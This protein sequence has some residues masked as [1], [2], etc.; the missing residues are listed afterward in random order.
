MKTWYICLS[1]DGSWGRGETVDAAKVAC[2]KASGSRGKVDAFL[3][4]N[5]AWVCSIEQDMDL[6]P[7]PPYVDSYGATCWW[8]D[9]YCQ[10]TV[11]S[12]KKNRK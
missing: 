10:K 1:Y 5:G 6:H 9:P 4:K 3:R 7:T 2:H 8:G 12:I 11:E